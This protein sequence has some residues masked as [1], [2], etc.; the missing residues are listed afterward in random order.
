[1]HA[2][3]LL[4]VTEPCRYVLVWGPLLFVP[5]TRVSREEYMGRESTRV[6]LTKSCLVAAL[7]RVLQDKALVKIPE[8]TALFVAIFRVSCEV[9]LSRATGRREKQT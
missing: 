8:Y 5:T 2:L 9:D 1:M 3:K 4:N 7:T 6:I